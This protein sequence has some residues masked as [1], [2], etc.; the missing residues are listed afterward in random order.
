MQA[1]AI[2]SELKALSS[3]SREAFVEGSRRWFGRDAVHLP[4][5]SD[6]LSTITAL[7]GSLKKGEC[8]SAEVKDD[9]KRIVLK[10]QYPQIEKNEKQAAA[11]LAIRE[12]RKGK[13]EIR[14]HLPALAVM[15]AD[16]NQSVV[17]AMWKKGHVRV[18]EKELRVTEPLASQLT[19][20]ML[21]KILKCSHERNLA[22][23]VTL[24]SFPDYPLLGAGA[25]LH[26]FQTYPKLQRSCVKQAIER[27][28]SRFGDH[29]LIAE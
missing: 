17:N 4:A 5:S 19:D 2:M 8:S 25:P 27:D 11:E 24:F 6:L 20:E 13:S 15:L 28:A 1:Q 10:L 18:E 7:Q 12:L 3:M 9:L 21:E 23:E 14:V 22:K 26:I 16:I 29:V